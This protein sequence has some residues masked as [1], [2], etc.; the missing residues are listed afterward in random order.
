MTDR[1]A[2]GGALIGVETKSPYSDRVCTPQET[3]ERVAPLFVQYGITRLARLTRLDCFDIPVWNAVRPNARSI[4]IHQGK[5]ITDIDAKVSAAM[6]ALERA[7]AED[8][9]VPSRT[10]SR[11]ELSAEG[12]ASHCLDCLVAAGQNPIGED[13]TIEWIEG[14]DLLDGQA[15]WVPRDA[16]SLDRTRPCRFWQ[17]SDGLAS[18]NTM[19]EA[20]FHGLLE[21]IE[22]DQEVLWK[23]AG[24]ARR[25]HSCLSA[26]SFDDGV[27]D[28]LAERIARRGF[29]LQLFDMTGDIGVPVIAAL[30]A[31]MDG[32]GTPALR[33]IDVTHG[34]G[35]HPVAARAAIRA[36]TEAVQSRLTLI[37]GTRDDVP[38]AL[39]GR[40]LPSAL[41]SDLALVPGHNRCA[42]AGMQGL[43]SGAMLERLLGI[44]RQRRLGPVI[45]VR[46][47]RPQ[48]GWAAAKLLMPSLE[49]PEGAR[50][51]PFGGR[52]MKTALVFR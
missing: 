26:A 49:N 21:R 19:Q 1:A 14:E 43:S 44:L 5:G 27:V 33:Y 31:P 32:V 45:A 28:A 16:V 36:I 25:A 48:D 42:D 51:Q 41:K 8:L 47:N 3:L 24:P 2:Q 20:V 23:L 35:A 29:R 30:L 46:L 40:A 37:S 18:G 9:R 12:L 39:Y 6:E 7:V 50:R 52:A 15:I 38:P 10:A 22:R 4:A 34:S 17:S 11:R 13:S